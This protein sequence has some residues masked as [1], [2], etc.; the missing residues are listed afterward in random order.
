MRRHAELLEAAEGAAREAAARAAEDKADALRRQEEELL[1]GFNMCLEEGKQAS[2]R[3]AAE[4]ELQLKVL[5]LDLAE[6]MEK[7]LEKAE[8]E[9][10]AAT[11]AAVGVA[12]AAAATEL[13][14]QRELLLGEVTDQIETLQ[15]RVA[16]AHVAH[17]AALLAAAEKHKA[18]M[19]KANSAV[20]VL[21]KSSA[22]SEQEVERLKMQI[23]E[24]EKTV[25]RLSPG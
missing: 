1:D 6:E 10:A 22:S 20:R 24:L 2:E 12:R 23:D 17:E 25:V 14:E 15:A 5:E 16:D 9:A 18:E 4:H 21:T 3:D 8:A 19:D 11:E 13:E 7:A